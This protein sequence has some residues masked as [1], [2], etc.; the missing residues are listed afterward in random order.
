MIKSMRPDTVQDE[1][2]TSMRPNDTVHNLLKVG[3]KAVALAQR[4]H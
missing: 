4:A 2:T 3:T 1:V